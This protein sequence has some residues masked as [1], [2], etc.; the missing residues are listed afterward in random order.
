[1][2]MPSKWVIARYWEKSPRR[3]DFAPHLQLDEPCCFACGSFA[4]KW[5]RKQDTPQSSWQRARLERSHVVPQGL[6]GPDDASNLLLLCRA[7]HRES[8]DWRDPEQMVRWIATR[9]ER[10]SQELET[11]MAWLAAAERAPDFGEALASVASE[12]GAA[13][14][15]S[16][17]LR[18]LIGQAGTHFGVG[19]SQGTRVA[20][21][22]VAAD[23]ISK[24]ARPADRAAEGA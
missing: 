24:R 5:K 6:G 13:V 1:M 7:C 10:P 16:E 17:I 23:E 15:V 19:Y 21:L 12:E 4:E 14:R 2:T 3:R 8:P 22:Q 20:V 11:F 18:D 9:D